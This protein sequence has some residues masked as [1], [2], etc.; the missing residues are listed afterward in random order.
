M[1]NYMIDGQVKSFSP[2]GNADLGS[3]L[4]GV[5][6]DL[7]IRGRYISSLLVN[8][9]EI[10]GSEEKTD[11][12]L[13]GIYSI[14]II[15]ESPPCLAGKILAEGQNYIGE[16]QDYLTKVAGYYTSGNA[17]ADAS[18]AES[19]QGIQWFVQMIDFIESSLKLDF[20]KLSLNGTSVAACVAILNRIL[21]EIVKAQEGCDPVQLADILEYDLVPHLGEWKSI[22]TLFEGEL[23]AN[24][25]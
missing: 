18:F 6:R 7:A 14:Q 11:R 9:E 19:V 4:G 24:F 23:K 15:T 5:N 2:C 22:F 13:E 17:C 8:G 10:A 16:L 3:L 25:S 20:Q 1:L 21:E 12:R